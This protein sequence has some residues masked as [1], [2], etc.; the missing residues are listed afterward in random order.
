MPGCISASSQLPTSLPEVHS[1]ITELMWVETNSGLQG[2]RGHGWGR[3]Y[4]PNSNC[5]RR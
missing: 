2:Q 3:G 5:G 1:V 4:S